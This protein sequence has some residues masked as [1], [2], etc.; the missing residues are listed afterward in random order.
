[1]EDHRGLPLFNASV[2]ELVY[3]PDSK[4]GPFGVVGSSP[5][6]GTKLNKYTNFAFLFMKLTTIHC[7]DGSTIKINVEH[8]SWVKET[9]KDEQ[10]N[11]IYEIGLPG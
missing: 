2:A 6:R 10:D 8:I 11:M 7:I 9:G 3:A 5:T 4:S 1:M